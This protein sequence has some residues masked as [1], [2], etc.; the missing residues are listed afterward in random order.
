MDISKAQCPECSRAL[1]VDRMVCRSCG[2]AVE[3]EIE[4]SA[5]GQ[6]D[7][8]EQVFVTAFLRSHGSIRRMESLFGVSYPTVKNRLNRI[9][10][11]LDAA[12]TP[13]PSDNAEVLDRLARG[14]ITTDQALE[15]LS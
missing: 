12:F 3:G 10:A 8:D 6:L 9:V 14:E 1:Q 7:L 2:V 4:V 11:R 13:P 5:L 15:E